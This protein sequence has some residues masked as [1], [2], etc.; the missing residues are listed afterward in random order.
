MDGAEEM[1]Q[2]LRVLVALPDIL[3]SVSSNHIVGQIH[4]QCDLLSSSGMQVHI[5]IEN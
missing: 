3:N 1:D 2:W 5:Q 4:P